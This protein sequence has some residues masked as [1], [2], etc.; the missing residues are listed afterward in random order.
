MIVKYISCYI[1][2][3]HGYI[4]FGDTYAICYIQFYITSS[5]LYS[6]QQHNKYNKKMLFN[7]TYMPREH[8]TYIIYT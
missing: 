3:Q 4:A 6:R 2:L 8:D 5:V 1:L 7:I